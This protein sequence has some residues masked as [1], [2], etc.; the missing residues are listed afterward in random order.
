MEKFFD[1]YI[2][3]AETPQLNNILTQQTWLWHDEDELLAYEDLFEHY[4]ER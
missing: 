1:K 3:G 4:H 2:G